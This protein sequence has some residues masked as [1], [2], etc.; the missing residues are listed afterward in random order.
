M[1]FFCGVDTRGDVSGVGVFA[2][3]ALGSDTFGD[4][5]FGVDTFGDDVLDAD[6][7]GEEDFGV[8]TFG[9]DV[10][11]SDTFG[12]DD[13]GVALFVTLGS[14]SCERPRNHENY[15]CK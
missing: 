5:V 12:V 14:F 6:I 15:K 4:S 10:L 3:D 7:F 13:L 9:E 1:E 8:E 2:A 11:G